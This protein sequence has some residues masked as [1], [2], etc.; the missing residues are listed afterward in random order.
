MAE[1]SD[2]EVFKYRE[3]FVV[4]WRNPTSRAG[5]ALSPEIERHYHEVGRSIFFAILIGP[6]CPPPNAEAREV[7]L[8]E[9]DRIHELTRAVRTV[10][11]SGS[12]RQTVM[13]SVMTAMTLA[14]GL[15]GKPFK[16]DKT[17]ADLAQVIEYTLGY[18]ARSLL[19]SMVMSGIVTPN[20]AGLT[21]AAS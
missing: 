2:Y 18:N 1:P 3:L 9:H 12:A 15:R 11:I 6:D 21:V 19:E 20:E 10:I 8:R 7:M 16:V 13:R 14:A 4:R 5:H 17:V